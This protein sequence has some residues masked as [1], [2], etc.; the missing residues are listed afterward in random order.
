MGRWLS[1]ASALTFRAGALPSA[2]REGGGARRLFQ[3]FVRR[4]A[5]QIFGLVG[6]KPHLSEE[7]EEEAGPPCRCSVFAQRLARSVIKET[8]Q[9]EEGQSM[10]HSWTLHCV[11]VPAPARS[12]PAAAR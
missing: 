7:E 8:P 10:S 6:A 9:S 4:A 3:F 5:E 1:L 11:S 2:K 12:W